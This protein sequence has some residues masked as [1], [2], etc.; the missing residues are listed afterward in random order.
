MNSLQKAIEKQLLDVPALCLAPLI[1]SKFFEQGIKVSPSRI[2]TI[3]RQI[4]KGKT[5]FA[6]PGCRT[7]PLQITITEEDTTE[8]VE[9]VNRFMEEDL[10]A[11]LENVQVKTSPSILKSLK[12]RWPSE[13][14][15]QLKEISEFRKRL[16]QR[17]GNGINKLRML[18]TLARDLG[19]N[20]N[21]DARNESGS[22]GTALVD[23][24]TRLHARSCQVTEEVIILLETGFADGAMAR[25]RTM[26]EI[27][28]T[29]DFIARH[30]N[31][32][33][34]RYKDHQ[35]VESHKGAQE[36]E[37]IHAKLG[38]EAIP[39]EELTK[40]RAEYDRVLQKYGQ[41]FVGQYGWAAKDL[42][43]KKPTFK[44]IE[45]SVGIDHLRGHYR[46]A[47]HGVHANPKGIFFSM[48][49]MFPTKM[50]LAGPS[51]SGLADAGHGAAHS[52]TLISA[53][54]MSLSPTFDHQI[55]VRT[56]DL[57]SEEIGS[58]FLRAHQKLYRDEERLRSEAVPSSEPASQVADSPTH[59]NDASEGNLA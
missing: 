29:A 25:W 33:A 16:N 30:G 22:L 3:A 23:V 24:I 44:D 5:N 13:R 26:H 14:R 52:L 1:K 27:S 43:M 4:L 39:V 47:S 28:V 12:R 38:Y 34:R 58:A 41:S 8:I 7:E 20:I 32:C 54:L 40:I 31:D 11:I 42:G 48:A 53:I 56:M 6:M 55:A 10:Q 37:L 18:V 46:M 15:M 49:A 19:N 50:L 2:R 59:S 21:H 45:K 51:N 9:K 17:W 35:I 36:Y 57:L